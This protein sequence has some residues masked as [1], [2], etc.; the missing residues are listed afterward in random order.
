M[1]AYFSSMNAILSEKGQI[2]IPKQLRIDLGLEA[3][4]VL[5]FVEQDG[6]LIISKKVESDPVDQWLGFA[7]TPNGESVEEYLNS[8][9]NR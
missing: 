7:K 3:G 4:A 8:I 6:R 2:T 5:E 9:R 1:N